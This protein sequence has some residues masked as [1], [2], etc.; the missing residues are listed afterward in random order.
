ML[1]FPPLTAVALAAAIVTAA[2][3]TSLLA[4]QERRAGRAIGVILARETGLP[5]TVGSARVMGDRVMLRDVHL[6]PG[7]HGPFELR[8]EALELR[9][10]PAEPGPTGGPRDVPGDIGVAGFLD[11]APRN[12]RIAAAPPIVRV[13]AEPGADAAAKNTIDAMRVRLRALLDSPAG[14]R[15]RLSGGQLRHRGTTYAFE[16]NGEKRAGDVTL[17]LGFQDR[18]QPEGVR[19][20]AHAIPAGADG[21]DIA[22]DLTAR[23]EQVAALMPVALDA[24]APLATRAT[25][26]LRRGGDA[27]ASGRLTVG[28]GE[29]AAAVDYAARH[30]ART[31]RVDATAA[32]AGGD[33]AFDGRLRY[34]VGDGAFD[35]V[36]NVT[37]FDASALWTRLGLAAPPGALRAGAVAAT[38]AGVLAEAA[39]TI[40]TDVRARQLSAFGV[41]PLDGALIARGRATR[42]ADLDLAALEPSTLTLSRDGQPVAVVT[43]ASAAGQAW[44]VTV[45]GRI[46]DF[47]RIAPL[48]G[49]D[50]KLAGS[51]R[52]VGEL[53]RTGSVG[54]SGR[55]DAR[56][57]R[58]T[59]TFPGPMEITNARATVPVVWRTSTPEGAGSLFVERANV[60]RLAVDRVLGTP[61][62]VDG[63]LAVPDLAYTHYA[64]RGG[65]WLEAAI[66]GRALPLRARVEG[67]HVDLDAVVRELASAV[68]RVTGRVGYFVSAQAS[69]A[70]GLVAVA[71]LHSEDDGGEIAIDALQR[72]LESPAVEV[73][74]TGILR[75][76][77]ENLRVFE[78]QTLEGEL[79]YAEGAGYIDLSLR[80]K[81]RLGIFPAPVEAINIRNMPLSVL[82]RA[83]GGGATP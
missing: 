82:E 41:G 3:W 16:V 77:L 24:R 80:G 29:S 35:G 69:V 44:P 31:G 51:A 28:T 7:P 19:L 79:R 71:R 67:E 27:A 53:R 58:A 14:L 15:V 8:A 17:A 21:V 32:S 56:L 12:L 72:L 75:R 34:T 63:L 60:F 5:V 2:G 50:T 62:L 73:E 42:G 36:V 57:D 61:R 46:D 23:G 38:F 43:A 64:G 55:V 39:V 78:Y 70:E 68:G 65:G 25:V 11:R 40:A 30:D 74:S 1:T 76:T 47:A 49:A 59:L 81:K 10:D 33:G 6:P 52:L 9:S 54:F 66:D 83:L 37:R 48:F 26:A 4:S 22:I 18:S 13:A 45:D 20:S